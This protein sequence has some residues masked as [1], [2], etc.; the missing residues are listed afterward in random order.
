MRSP[1]S[2][3]PPSASGR[4]PH[5]PHT[6]DTSL[7]RLPYTPPLSLPFNTHSAGSGTACAM[8]S[9]SYGHRQLGHNGP[10][11]SPAAEAASS[12]RL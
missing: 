6:P 8:R 11:L 1:L 7:C 10:A 5:K 3:P 9:E 4:A 2:A 12:S